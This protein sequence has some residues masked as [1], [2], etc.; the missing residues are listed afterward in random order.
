MTGKVL[1][2]NQD[3]SAL[4][5]CGIKKAFLLLWLEKAETVSSSKNL[6]LRT[7]SRSFPAPSVIRLNSYVKFPY[8]GVVLT[9]QNIYRRDGHRCAYCGTSE[10]LTLD[11]VM[12][13]SRGGASSWDNWVT[14]CKTCNAKKGDYTP[15]EAGMPL[16]KKPFKPSFIMFLKDLS[17]TPEEDW[18]PY[19][20]HKRT[21]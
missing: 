2:L 8:K 21:A 5:V 13:K 6:F 3:Y 9:R 14:A 20:S 16:R 15:E 7:I 17:G 11:H 10:S 19:L 1:I 4:T 12:P 18:L